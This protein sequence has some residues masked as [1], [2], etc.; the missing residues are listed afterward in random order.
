MCPAMTFINVITLRKKN[1]PQANSKD[2]NSVYFKSL[3][4]FLCALFS[5]LVWICVCLITNVDLWGRQRDFP[6]D[7][8]FVEQTHREDTPGAV[9]GTTQLF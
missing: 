8:L 7:R 6:S 3:L 2:S 4:H 5:T 1:D 9:G